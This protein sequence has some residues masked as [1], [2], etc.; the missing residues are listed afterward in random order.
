M[1]SIEGAGGEAEARAAAAASSAGLLP[2]NSQAWN[3]SSSCSPETRSAS[4]MNCGMVPLPPARRVVQAC[5]MRK[6]SR[7]PTS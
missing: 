3:R 7:S 5:R 1:S 2:V 4:L 6:K